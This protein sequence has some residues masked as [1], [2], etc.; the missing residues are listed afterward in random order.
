MVIE[1]LKFDPVFV[2]KNFVD[3]NPM[4]HHMYA[5]FSGQIPAKMLSDSGI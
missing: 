2:Y 1:V 3:N 4:V 5:L